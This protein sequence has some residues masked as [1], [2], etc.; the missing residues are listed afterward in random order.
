MWIP[1]LR[2]REKENK[3]RGKAKV[4]QKVETKGRVLGTRNLPTRVHGIN[5]HG[6]SSHGKRIQT[7]PRVKAKA[8]KAKVKVIMARVGKVANVEPDAWAQEQQPAATAGDQ[9]EPEVTAPFTLGRG[10]ATNVWDSPRTS[11]RGRSPR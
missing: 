1:L 2:V 6:I 5:S 10:H 9:P 8:R 11:H 4:S 3:I 7:M